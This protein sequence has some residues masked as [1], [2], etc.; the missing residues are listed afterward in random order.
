MAQ[1]KEVTWLMTK[2]PDFLSQRHIMERSTIAP[3]HYQ[4]RDAA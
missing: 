4:V 3:Q 2:L 1:N